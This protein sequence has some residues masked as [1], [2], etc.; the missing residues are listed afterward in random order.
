MLNFSYKGG[1]MLATFGFL[2]SGVILLLFGNF[3]RS[4]NK[5]KS[6]WA[7]YFGAAYMLVG[8]AV[9]L[10]G[11]VCLLSATDYLVKS[12]IVGDALFLLASV[13]C[14]LV[15]SPVRLR[16]QVAWLGLLVSAGLLILRVRNYYP[17]PVI[18]D[19]VLFFNTQ[20]P[21]AILLSIIIITIWLPTNIKVARLVT[22]KAH[23]VRY[24]SLYIAIY[25]MPVIS[26]ALFVQ[27]HR[28]TVIIQAYSIFTLSALL[29][30]A[31]N[32]LLKKAKKG[33]QHAA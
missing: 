2:A 32:F 16:N 24:R 3:F 15:L 30:L 21:V 17:N 1:L 14:L 6:A 19:G 5:S 22:N 28:R 18:Q 7:T 10:W 29:M 27:A 4:T 25:S 26:A 23:M 33:G 11:V 8:V 31:S 20:Q 13:L 9:L 12:V